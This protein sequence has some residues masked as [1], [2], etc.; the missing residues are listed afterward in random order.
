MKLA[1]KRLTE[2]CALIVLVWIKCVLSVWLGLSMVVAVGNHVVA[3]SN[4]RLFECL[5]K[6]VDVCVVL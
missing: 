5:L 4:L 6:D 3:C 1:I 2:N